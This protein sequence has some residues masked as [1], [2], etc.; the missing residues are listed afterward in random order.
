MFRAVRVLFA[1][2]NSEELATSG[3]FAIFSNPMY[4]AWILFIIPGFS[5]F[6]Y[7]WLP[8]TSSLVMYICLRIFIKEEEDSLREKF[9]DRYD[10]YRK[11]VLIK[12]L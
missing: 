4:A 9:G 10:E 1:A 8:L 12:L 2:L 11:N 5:F 7:S 6:I 3:P